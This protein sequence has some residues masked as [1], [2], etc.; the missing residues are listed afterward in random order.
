M[1]KGFLLDTSFISAFAPDRPRPAAVVE[2]WVSVQSSRDGFYFSVVV[3][4]EIERGIAKLQRLGQ[5]GRAERLDRWLA[6]T[7]DEFSDR[8][9]VVDARVAREAGGLDDRVVARGRNPGLADVLL[10]ATARVHDLALLT[11]NERH[12]AFLEVEHFN[13]L[14]GDLPD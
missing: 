7:L 10:A 4:A 14:A 12:F 2:H 3:V 11:A 9:L 6:V 8:V 13:P 1:R 5:A